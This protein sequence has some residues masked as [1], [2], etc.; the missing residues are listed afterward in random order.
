LN[1]TTIEHIQYEDLKK[2]GTLTPEWFAFRY[3]VG[4]EENWKQV[5]GDNPW[6]WF[7]PYRNSKGDGVNF[8]TR[9]GYS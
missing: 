3:D 4:P 9:E 8:P 2:D 6:L 5:F 1:R 7:V